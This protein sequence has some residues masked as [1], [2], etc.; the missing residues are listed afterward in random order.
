[1]ALV[2]QEQWDTI[3]TELT[4]RFPSRSPLRHLGEGEVD[5]LAGMTLNVDGN[6]HVLMVKALAE[7]GDFPALELLAE[8]AGADT[9][10]YP[11]R[12]G[13]VKLAKAILADI[14]AVRPAVITNYLAAKKEGRSA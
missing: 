12:A 3:Y 6:L 11:E 14:E 2:P 10:R 9:A 7:I 13:D 4:R 8:V 5:T 1:M